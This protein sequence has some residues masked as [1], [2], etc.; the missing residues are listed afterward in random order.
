MT[1]GVIIIDKP[2]GKTS[3]A[4]VTEVKKLLG[5]R[6]AGHTGTLD[7]MATGVLPVC[8]DEATKLA[9][10]LTGEDKEYRATMLLGVKTD[11][12]DVEGKVIGGSD[13][14]VSEEAIRTALSNMVGSIKQVPPA[15]S[16][17]K[18]QGKPLYQWARSNVFL[19][20]QAREVKIHDIT[21][22]KIDFPRVTFRVC[23]SKGTYIR[24]LCS[25][26]GEFL[27]TGACL[28]ELRRLKS[29]YF[30]EDKAVSLNGT[31]GVEKKLELETKILPL[32]ALLP[33]FPSVDLSDDL[34]RKIRN[35]WQ[36]TAQMF[37][38]CQLPLLKA[39]DM[40]KLKHDGCLL[41]VARMLTTV[42]NIP[43][44]EAKKPAAKILRVFNK[45]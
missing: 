23:C 18:F 17:V 3:H 24:T 45:H 34:A 31:G 39:G 12:L 2:T 35:G 28:S 25:D 40:I 11:T 20:K 4:V 37:Q 21:I 13:K 15:F 33:S 41:A 42:G 9:G 19:K 29:G 32:S 7:P 26:I 36:P 6:K 30:T 44:A 38:E 1:D 8:L 5:V 43:E 16:A 14:M 10:F 22:E 27:G